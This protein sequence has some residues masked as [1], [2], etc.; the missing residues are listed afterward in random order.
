M[1]GKSHGW[2]SLVGYCPWGCKELDTTE[3]L[4]CT[5]LCVDSGFLVSSQCRPLPPSSVC[6]GFMPFPSFLLPS[7]FLSC[8][9]GYSGDTVSSLLTFLGLV[10]SDISMFR[11]RGLL[12]GDCCLSGFKGNRCEPGVS[13]LFAVPLPPRAFPSP[14]RLPSA[15]VAEA[16]RLEGPSRRC[17]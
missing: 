11:V 1:P 12:V 13:H 4:H 17:C 9:E 3:Q 2:R 10:P 5:Y 15:L 8:Y 7:F 14:P 16:S 6:P